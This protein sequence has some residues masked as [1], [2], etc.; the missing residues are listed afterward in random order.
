MSGPSTPGHD[1]SVDDLLSTALRPGADREPGLGADRLAMLA[2]HRAGRIRRRRHV[3]ATAVGTGA[4]VA[5]T[6]TV[7]PVLGGAGSPAPQVAAP[8]T[9]SVQPSI[10]L[11]LEPSVE[12]SVQPLLSTPEGGLLVPDDVVPTTG[13]LPAGIGA[14][15]SD[16]TSPAG[17]FLQEVVPACAEA[18]GEGSTA[19]PGAS[20]R[21]SRT[22]THARDAGPAVA[23]VDLYAPGA[24]VAAWL[25][26]VD[27]ATACQDAGL[28]L[29]VDT[30]RGEELPG[31]DGYLLVTGSA[32]GVEGPPEVGVPAT[33][34]TLV[35]ARY[36]DVLVRVQ[37]GTVGE[38]G[39]VPEPPDVLTAERLALAYVA[40]LQETRTAERLAVTP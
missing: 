31:A 29:T 3:V 25:E 8:P 12:P 9:A 37:L 18:S 21:G 36:G 1:P 13:A 4:L 26:V 38:D 32:P 6:L 11:S 30:R 27:R 28:G 17:A 7:V 24:A 2:R 35:V 15:L 39:S 22:W 10:E 19:E 23:R 16:T 34:S 20:S 5:L 14:A 40:G 33:A